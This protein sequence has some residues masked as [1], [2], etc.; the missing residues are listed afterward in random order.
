VERP[1][2]VPECVERW[3]NFAD[4]KDQVAR[5]DAFLSEDCLPK[6]QRG[7]HLGPARVNSYVKPCRRAPTR[8]KGLRIP[9]DA[10][11]V[12]AHRRVRPLRWFG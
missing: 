2:H 11:D 7:H 3:T 12:G 9:E 1:L 10:G 5:W 8:H 4:P 6:Q